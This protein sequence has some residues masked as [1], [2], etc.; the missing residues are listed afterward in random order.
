M[1]DFDDAREETKGGEA[2]GLVPPEAPP[3]ITFPDFLTIL[4]AHL[5]ECAQAQGGPIQD[6]SFD[7]ALLERPIYGRIISVVGSMEPPPLLQVC[8][9][10]GYSSDHASAMVMF[11]VD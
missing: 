1:A 6:R 8:R 7:P 9:D 10:L 11:S 4:E 2:E 5:A 3:R